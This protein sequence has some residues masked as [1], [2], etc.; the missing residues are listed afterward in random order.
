MS[1]KIVLVAVFTLS[2][3][4]FYFV[5]PSWGCGVKSTCV[6]QCYNSSG[7]QI[8]NNVPCSDFDTAGSCECYTDAGTN[9][10]AGCHSHCT[11]T[12]GQD[13]YCIF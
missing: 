9:G 12:T 13:E 3:G 6:I 1:Q 10:T 5:S 11:S 4:L 2:V 7:Q 8:G